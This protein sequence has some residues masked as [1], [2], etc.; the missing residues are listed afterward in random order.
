MNVSFNVFKKRQAFFTKSELLGA[1]IVTILFTLSLVFS[2]MYEEEIAWVILTNG[3]VGQIVYVTLCVAGVVFAPLVSLA[4][5]P[6]AVTAWG[7]LAT[8]AFTTLG[9]WVGTIITFNLAKKYGQDFV[10]K[11]VSMK[12]AKEIARRV[13]QK[14]RLVTLTLL[15]YVIPTDVLSYVVGLLVPV[16]ATTY[17][18][19]SLIG[20][21]PTAFIFSYG[22]TL[23]LG[24]QVVTVAILLFTILT[25]SFVTV[26]HEN[27]DS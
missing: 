9:W 17:A 5:L 19:A 25:I 27:M 11:F 23:P 1:V 13:T 12:R 15:H 4:L 21:L 20:T 3:V 18:Y 6:I 24:Y 7:S 16:R 10:S 8:A 14:N 2:R 26:S 22:V